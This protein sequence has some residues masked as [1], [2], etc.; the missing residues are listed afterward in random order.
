MTQTAGFSVIF[1]L[2][3]Q[4]LKACMLA[5]RKRRQE[6]E[7]ELLV[8]HGLIWQA[9]DNPMPPQPETAK[10]AAPQEAAKAITSPA[11]PSS[12]RSSPEST[13]TK[14]LGA[15]SPPLPWPSPQIQEIARP[16]HRRFPAVP[17]EPE[18][19]LSISSPVQNAEPIAVPTESDTT[20]AESV[21]LPSFLSRFRTQ[22]DAV[23]QVFERCRQ[24]ASEALLSTKAA[25]GKLQARVENAY[26]LS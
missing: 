4:H 21:S 24:R 5:W 6:E 3:F 12:A 7:E 20:L 11:P 22:R 13:T 16:V 26:Q 23:M 25:V 19:P 18:R 17:P 15:I 10:S 14:K 9:T 8:P 1:Y 2:P